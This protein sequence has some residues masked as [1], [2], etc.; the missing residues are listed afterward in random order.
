MSIGTTLR[1]IRN[2]KG[3]KPQKKTELFIK[4]ME[5]SRYFLVG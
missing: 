5:I 1:F 4:R 2:L 3:F